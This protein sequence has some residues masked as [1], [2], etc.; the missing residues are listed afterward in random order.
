MLDKTTATQHH[1]LMNWIGSSKVHMRGR[2]GDWYHSLLTPVHKASGVCQGGGEGDLVSPSES[3]V[4]D[5]SHT[6]RW[7]EVDAYPSCVWKSGS[8]NIISW[9]EACEWNSW[10]TSPAV[11]PL[12]KDLWLWIPLDPHTSYTS[13]VH[14]PWG[15]APA[16]AIPTLTPH[17][18]IPCRWRAN[19]SQGGTV[20]YQT[21]RPH[22]SCT[23]PL[24][25]EG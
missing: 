8:V 14:I 1:E 9:G 21:I 12:L 22:T 18:Q 5:L 7:A 13:H 24:Q 6:P 4:C 2:G 17:V 19:A 23:D 11:Q 20:F 15:L 10:H 3:L 16:K 25:V